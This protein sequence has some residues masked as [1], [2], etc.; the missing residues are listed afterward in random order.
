MKLIQAEFEYDGASMVAWVDASWHIRVG[1]IVEFRGE[2][3]AWT[4]KKVY[5]TEINHAQ[6]EVKWGLALP[7]SQRTER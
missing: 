1:Q 2:V 3:G 5:E 4:V 6:L 7:S